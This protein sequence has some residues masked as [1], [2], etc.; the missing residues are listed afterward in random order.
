MIL[1]F[2][3][4]VIFILSSNFTLSDEDTFF[5]IKVGEYISKNG[6]PTKDPFSIHDLSYTPHEWLSDFIFYKIFNSFGY[7][8]LAVFLSLL[9][10]ILIFILYKTNNLLN[11]KT[12][13]L[14]FIFTF[15]S[16]YVLDIFNFIV[17]R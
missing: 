11:G 7:L 9:M 16:I 3:L 10:S 12:N 2:L 4:I 17:V 6:F 15:G 14:S 13:Y 1:P 8:G 5:H